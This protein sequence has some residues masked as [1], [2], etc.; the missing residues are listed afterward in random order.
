MKN[1]TLSH[2]PGVSPPET[3]LWL[4]VI[5]RALRDSTS[6]IYGSETRME[7][8]RARNWLL[9]GGQDFVEV[10][11][12]ANLDPGYVRRRVLPI[13]ERGWTRMPREMKGIRPTLHLATPRRID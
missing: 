11:H 10:C 12:L 6:T 2:A 7:R 3:A 9:A 4:A 1:S 13:Q 5:F 8:E